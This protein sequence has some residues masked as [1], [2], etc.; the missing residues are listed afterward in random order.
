MCGV[1]QRTFAVLTPKPDPH[2]QSAIASSFPN[3]YQYRP[4]IFLV[5]AGAPFLL[6]KDVAEE[7]GI[8]EGRSGVVLNL[9]VGY[10]GLA[11]GDLW[12][13]LADTAG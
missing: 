4:D 7:L 9:K 11:P 2:I 1:S 6:A 10:W 8:V 3:H 12:E 13:W 5:R